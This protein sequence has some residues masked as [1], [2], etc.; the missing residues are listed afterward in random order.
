MSPPGGEELIDRILA[1]PRSAEDLANDLLIEFNRGYPIDALSQLLSSTDADVV[2]A[3]AWLASELPGRLGPLAPNAA[4]LVE[5]PRPDVRFFALD[6]VL[7]NVVDEGEQLAAALR[8]IDDEDSGVR[9]KAMRFA[10]LAD[11]GQ[12]R[13]AAP[14]LT[15]AE[16]A[17]LYA[18]GLLPGDA[19]QADKAKAGL[20]NHDIVVRRWS[21]AA[22]ARLASEA[23]L[24]LAAGSGDEDVST[25]SAQE[26]SRLR[27]FGPANPEAAEHSHRN[28][29]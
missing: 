1:A 10:A 19:P 21:A 27:R 29:G 13:S 4:S 24:E 28:R 5:H 11:D 15:D 12:L 20:T 23:L 25:F 2:A 8:L 22:A 3:A 6:V 7:D 9:W 26:L 17:R 16:R 14:V 18:S